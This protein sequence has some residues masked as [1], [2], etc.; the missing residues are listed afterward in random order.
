MIQE[1]G[2]RVFF[3]LRSKF[4][5]P[6]RPRPYAES[7]GDRL[8]QFAFSP[9][10]ASHLS[11][12][13]LRLN[14]YYYELLDSVAWTIPNKE[15]RIIDLGSKNFGYCFAL[16]ESLRRKNWE[17]E[18]KGLELDPYRRFVSYYRRIDH[19]QFFVGLA[20]REFSPE[21]TLDYQEGDWLNYS[22]DK[23]FDLVFCFFPFLFLDLHHQWG[24]SR[25]SF[26]PKQFYQKIFA[27]SDQAILVHQGREEF[28]CSRQLL[29]DLKIDSSEFCELHQSQW[30]NLRIPSFVIYAK[31]KPKDLSPV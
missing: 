10:I 18:L 27:Q 16:A 30:I 28:D 20:N 21:I 14:L 22:L 19:A 17:G 29:A 12:Q 7:G 23:K 3:G 8:V 25:K 2:N 31:R 5:I 9:L 24:L 13:N 4:S 1:F 26:S 11:P 6:L 15:G